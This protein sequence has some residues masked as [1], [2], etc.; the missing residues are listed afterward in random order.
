VSLDD[1]L[2][3]QECFDELQA[4]GGLELDDVL[5]AEPCLACGHLKL[6]HRENNGACYADPDKTNAPSRSSYS[7]AEIEVRK[8]FK[9]EYWCRTF[10]DDTK[11][12]SAQI[13]EYGDRAALYR[14]T[15]EAFDRGDAESAQLMLSRYIRETPGAERD[16]V[17]IEDV[18]RR[19]ATQHGP[20]VPLPT[21]TAEPLK[22]GV[23][24][25]NKFVKVDKTWEIEFGEESCRLP[26]SLIG[27]DYIPV[28]LQCAGEMITAVKLRET[29]A[30]AVPADIGTLE[31]LRDDSD[32]DLGAV[33]QTEWR[34]D[35]VLDE[36]ARSEYEGELKELRE[37]IVIAQ[38]TGNLAEV[39]NL[40]AKAEFI[41]AEL[42]KQTKKTGTG[43][44]FS[45]QHENARTTVTHAIKRA[46]EEI[47]KY[48]PATAQHLQL[49]IITGTTLTY[50][51]QS[52]R[53]KT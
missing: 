47:A 3:A 8:K 53:W 27:L 48:A 24:P 6:L 9:V 35:L 13:L 28:L 5:P 10:T 23:P 7:Q 29:G 42:R 26:A 4:A 36:K 16:D 52:V 14:G 19:I 43:R 20:A 31:E 17:W 33:L 51:D 21:E 32:P 18:V 1:E 34:S 41:A 44:L 11:Q 49:N 30:S 50:R 2:A 37:N 15:N 39:S 12:A 38:D 40:T 46:V 25:E 45:T 22:T